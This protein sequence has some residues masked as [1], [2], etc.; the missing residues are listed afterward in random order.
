MVEPHGGVAKLVHRVCYRHTDN[1]FFITELALN[2]LL[3]S[4]LL[5]CLHLLLCVQPAFWHTFI[6]SQ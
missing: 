2:V 5:V 6:P 3:R 4:H 1:S